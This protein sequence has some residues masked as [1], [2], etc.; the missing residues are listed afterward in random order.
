M[1]A[2]IQQITLSGPGKNSLSTE[3]LQHLRAELRAADGRPVLLT[4]DG[5]TFCA[6]LNLVEVASLTPDSAVPF[7]ELL[8]DTVRELFNYPGPTV[9]YING[10]A[11]AGGCVVA[12]ACDIRVA[13]D[14][15]K[16]RIGLNEAAIGLRFPPALLRMASHL[17]PAQHRTKVI[18]GA[19]LFAPKQAR[20]LGLLDEVDEDAAITART[21]LTRLAGHPPDIYS[22]TKADLRAGVMDINKD[23]ERR[24]L[25][26]IMPIWTSERLKT[27]IAAILNKSS[28]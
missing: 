11:I 8:T 12:L 5:D 23:E 22:A 10:H 28:K 3:L 18:L 6:G 25:N 1:D 13:V 26:E 20:R 2:S 7:L 15:D 19:G 16:T 24:F 4:G 17:L 27:A 21:I 14:N 9:A